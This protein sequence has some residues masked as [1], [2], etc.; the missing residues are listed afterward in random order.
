M[1]VQKYWDAVL[2][3]QAEVMRT[4]FHKEARIRWINTNEGFTVEEFIR[5]NCEYPGNWEGQIERTVAADNTLFTIVHVFSADCQAS[6][7]VASLIE[8]Q[9]DKI[10]SLDEIWGDDGPAPQW[11]LDLRLG[12]PIHS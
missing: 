8:I 3:Q 5:A 2:K 10:I 7:H 6:F 1:D 4:Y 11:R 12:R 9:G